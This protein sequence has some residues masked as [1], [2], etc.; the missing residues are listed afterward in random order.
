MGCS[1]SDKRPRPSRLAS[2]TVTTAVVLKN[3][4]MVEA[5]TTPCTIC[6]DGVSSITL[7]D[8]EMEVPGFGFLT[9]STIQEGIS[10]LLPDDTVEDCQKLRAMSTL[11]GCPKPAGDNACDLCG[12]SLSQV[13]SSRSDA[14]LPFL[15]HLFQGSDG[16]A[17][18][19]TVTCGLLETYLYSVESDMP[20]C[21]S[22]QELLFD[23]CCIESLG[24]SANNAI[25]DQNNHSCKIQCEDNVTL[26][27]SR[28]HEIRDE[29]WN[30][31]FPTCQQVDEALTRSFMIIPN[32]RCNTI[33]QTDLASECCGAENRTRLPADENDAALNDN[34][35][36]TAV[37]NVGSDSC[38]LCRDGSQ[39][40]LPDRTV[41]FAAEQFGFEPTC[42]QAETAV[43]VFETDST[44]CQ[45]AQQIGSYCGC[46]PIENACILC[47]NEGDKM[48][49]PDRLHV[50]TRERFGHNFTCS[51][52]EL[53]LLQLDT[54]THECFLAHETNW[55]CGCND[56]FYGFMGTERKSQKD[57]LSI[58]SRISGS[59]SVMGAL[60]IIV[61]FW[62]G[63]RQNIYRQI[64]LCMSCF[65]IITAMCWII[66]SWPLP[67]LDADGND[68]NT[69][70][71][72]GSDELCTA[73]G[74]CSIEFFLK[75]FF[76]KQISYRK[77][78]YL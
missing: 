75:H 56:G 33:F 48:T 26:S 21:L 31:L 45:E 27:T 62:R 32:D 54:N 9:C 59:L 78:T 24:T 39:V 30:D 37:V 4:G 10:L 70:G 1:N 66:G 60:F 72:N 52:L 44:E 46:P 65:D 11:C 19:A 7:P 2:L 5:T 55:E 58:L 64:M 16:T 51:E 71:A 3:A 73:Q 18:G 6:A 35:D 68:A 17:V 43:L 25:M 69:L 14:T 22:T 63:D 41:A 20:M 34:T 40:T 76:L 42:R 15:N 77:L 28:D 74:T 29:N 36:N 49:D 38:S 50:N 57:L 61:D 53:V 13:P 8:A 67:P 12:S 47:P 23:H